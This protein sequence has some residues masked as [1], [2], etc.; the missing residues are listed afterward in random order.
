MINRLSSF[1][2]FFFFI[3]SIEF[4]GKDHTKMGAKATERRL[5]KFF[6]LVGEH[7]WTQLF[8]GRLALT[9]G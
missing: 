3:T 8:E 9:R 6:F 2:F 5:I 4:L 1:F 7:D